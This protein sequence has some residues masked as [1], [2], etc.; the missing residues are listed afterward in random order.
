MQNGKVIAY[1]TRKLK[2]HEVNYP[3]HDL[4]FAG[5]VFTLKKWRYYLYSVTFE[6]FSDHKSLKYLFSQKELNMR[7]R[8]WV[9]FLQ[10]Y[11]CTVNYHPEK[12]NVVTNTLS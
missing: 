3:A 9:E 5:V 4:E 2:T 11:D 8:R 6:V 12:S 7:Q 10:D 1:A